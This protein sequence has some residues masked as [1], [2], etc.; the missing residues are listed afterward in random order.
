MSK[1]AQE[2][3]SQPVCW[4]R[5]ATLADSSLLDRLS[6]ELGHPLHIVDVEFGTEVLGRRGRMPAETVRALRQRVGGKLDRLPA[7]RP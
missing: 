2:L 4:A 5:S 1:T 3:A 6:T 7:R